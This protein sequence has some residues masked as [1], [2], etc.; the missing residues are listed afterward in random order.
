MVP[1]GGE[2]DVKLGF[3]LFTWKKDD[4]NYNY[5]I[6]ADNSDV[7]DDDVDDDDDDIDVRKTSPRRG[8]SVIQHG[9]KWRHFFL[10][11]NSFL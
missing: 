4:D 10:A 2:T 7:D 3:S 11:K 8:R 5:D 6:N 9:C 1:L